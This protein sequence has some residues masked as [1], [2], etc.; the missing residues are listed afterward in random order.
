KRDVGRKPVA[1]LREQAAM[2]L[3]KFGNRGVE[4][5]S[6]II[7]KIAGFE[8]KIRDSSLNPVKKARALVALFFVKRM[9]WEQEEKERNPGRQEWAGKASVFQD[10]SQWFDRCGN[11]RYPK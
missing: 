6:E 10:A 8:Q 5:L 11:I 7:N 3:E 9:V 1:V 4:G 2:K